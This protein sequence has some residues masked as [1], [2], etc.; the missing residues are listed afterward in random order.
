MNKSII[1]LKAL[2]MFLC[3]ICLLKVPYGY[4]IFFRFVALIL[5]VLFAIDSY[6]KS[7]TTWLVIWLVS[8]LLVNPIIKTP[9]GR[10][11]WNLVDILWAILL[12]FSLTDSLV[13]WKSKT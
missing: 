9:L 1:A 4:F 11:F 5:F 12:F 7:N 3:L 10:S 2:L 6:K 8:A 13:T